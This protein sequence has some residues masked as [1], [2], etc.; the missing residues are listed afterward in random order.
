MS[1]SELLLARTEESRGLSDFPMGF[2]LVDAFNRLRTLFPPDKPFCAWLKE[3]IVPP[4][5]TFLCFLQTLLLL[6][7]LLAVF[8]FPILICKT[9]NVIVHIVLQ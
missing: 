1:R 7:L 6:L 2:S 5:S 8:Y 4:K 3:S 9:I